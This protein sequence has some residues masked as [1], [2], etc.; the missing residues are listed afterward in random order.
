MIKWH[1]NSYAGLCC[2]L[3][4]SGALTRWPGTA[5][6]RTTEWSGT[7]SRKSTPINEH[8]VVVEGRT[9]NG[10][11]CRVVDNTGTVPRA[12]LEAFLDALVENQ[13]FG[14]GGISATGGNTIKLGEPELAHVQFGETLYR[15][16]LMPYEARIERF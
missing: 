16:I 3:I 2:K 4:N 5:H 8:A 12:E 15:L 7:L 9:H 1:L 13:R 10:K 11:E 6:G 14:L